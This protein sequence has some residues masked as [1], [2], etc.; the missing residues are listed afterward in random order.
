MRI[1]PVLIRNGKVHYPFHN[2]TA[3]DPKP[4]QYYHTNFLTFIT[5][6]VPIYGPLTLD[7]ILILSYFKLA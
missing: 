4:S 2:S 1:V 6:I 5:V 7:Q 3:L